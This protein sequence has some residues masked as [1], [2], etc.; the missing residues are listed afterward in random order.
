MLF[1]IGYKTAIIEISD[2][3]SQEKG[4]I[5]QLN[6]AREFDGFQLQERF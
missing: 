1:E 3:I 4:K 5:L 6:S 2:S